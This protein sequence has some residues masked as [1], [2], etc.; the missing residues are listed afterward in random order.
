[1]GI[2]V[3]VSVIAILGGIEVVAMVKTSAR[4][5]AE[6][7]VIDPDVLCFTAVEKGRGE[8]GSFNVMIVVRMKGVVGI[9]RQLALMKD[10][11]LTTGLVDRVVFIPVRSPR[12][13][14]G[15]QS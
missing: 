14:T 7:K 10:H 1:M 3:G 9:V 11:I 12:D 4:P 13:A 5:G 8:A 2:Y 15:S 6:V